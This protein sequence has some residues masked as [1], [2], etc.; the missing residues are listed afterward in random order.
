MN[1]KVEMAIWAV[2]L[3]PFALLTLALIVHVIL[4]D[5][6]KRWGCRYLGWHNGRGAAVGFDG[7]SATSTCSVCGKRV[8]QDSQ[9]NWF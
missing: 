4:P 1:P 3:V 5:K 8:L 9:G 6:Y 2:V 7:C